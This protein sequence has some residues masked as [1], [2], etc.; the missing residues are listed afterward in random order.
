MSIEQEVEALKNIP[1]FANIDPSRLKLMA[2]ASER[3]I[4]KEGKELFHQGDAGDAAYI[5]IEGEA[6][7][8]VDTD[9]GPLVVASFGKNDFVGEI[10]ILCDVPR[11]AT[12]KAKSE[13]ITLKITKEL[14]FNMVMDFP[15]MGVE[16]M[17]VLAHRIDHT[18]SQLTEARNALAEKTG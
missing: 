16:V 5:F 2:F 3:L 1:L 9:D 17:R 6:D 4:F 12:I 8:I 15:E 13:L 18:T 7:V 14:F 10:A 11:T